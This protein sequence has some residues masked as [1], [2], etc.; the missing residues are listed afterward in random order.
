MNTCETCKHMAGTLCNSP[1]H[2]FILE[3][4]HLCKE[5]EYNPLE[6]ECP[7]LEW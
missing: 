7:K 2:D 6:E 4:E 1:L 5:Y 3:G